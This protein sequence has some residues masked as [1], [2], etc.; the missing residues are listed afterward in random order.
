MNLLSELPRENDAQAGTAVDPCRARVVQE[1]KHGRAVHCCRFDS[2]GKY[3]FVGSEDNEIQQWH[4]ETGVK[5]TLNGHDSW[6]RG[7]AFPPATDAV[8]SSGY[9]GRLIWW[10][11]ETSPP[12]ETKRWQAHRGWI[13]CLA[14]SPDGRFLA[15]GGND[16]LVKVWSTADQ[17]P[18]AQLTGHQQQVYSLAFHSDGEH[19]VSADYQGAVKIWEM[20]T[21]R[22][23]REL[24]A[25][26]MHVYNKANR[27]SGG[28]LR[29]LAFSS[30]GRFLV[31]SG[32]VGGGD[33]LGQAVNP[34]ASVFDWETGQRKIV[35]RGRGDELGVAW[36]LTC[37]PTAGFVAAVSGG[38]SARH[39]YFWK[40]DQERP[41][42][43][44]ELPSAGRD[45]SLHPDGMHLAVALYDGRIQIYA[46]G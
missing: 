40:M 46:L 38:M 39:L 6:V 10:T 41:F 21:W 25:S 13:R 35:L 27:G 33:P 17:K 5:T 23:S 24:D 8:V 37:H 3:L 9:D 28:G 4:V 20:A 34:G 30:D 19:L 36:G 16:L 1:L 43:V 42:H 11:R 31:G 44:V 45:T 29:S 2:A 14:V 18:V 7:F 15:S 26:S 22:Q 12:R 32:V